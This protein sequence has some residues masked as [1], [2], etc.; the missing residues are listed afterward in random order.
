MTHRILWNNN[1]FQMSL[2]VLFCLC[3]PVFSATAPIPI[4]KIPQITAEKASILTSAKT[5]EPEAWKKAAV[6]RTFKN[7]SQSLGQ[8]PV[9]TEFYLFHDDTQLLVAAHCAE[10]DFSNAKAFPRNTNDDL[11][12]DESVQIVLGLEG[13]INTTVAAGG[14]EGAYNELGKCDHIYEMTTNLVGVSSRRYDETALPNA[15]FTSVLV[16]SENSWT[17]LFHIPFASVG[18]DIKK[19]PMLFFNAFR[20][21]RSERYGW[22]LPSFGGYSKL[23]MAQAQLLTQGHDAEATV[24][25]SL[26]PKVTSQTTQP[27]VLGRLDLDYYAAAGEVGAE[28]PSGREGSSIT[29]TVD[30]EKVSGI[31]SRHW[32]TRL[33]LPVKAA[34][35]TKI[36]AM[37][38]C[39]GK[40]LLKKEFTVKEPL[41][42]RTNVAKEYLDERVVYPWTSP[43][44]ADGAVSLKHGSIYFGEEMLPVSIKSCRNKEILSG[45]ITLEAEANGQPVLVNHR[46]SFSKTA[47]AIEMASNINPGWELKTRTEYDGF[48]TVR[49]RLTGLDTTIPDTLRLH[50]P[51]AKGLGQYMI[52]D[53]SQ[54]LI[55][56]GGFGYAGNMSDSLWVG[57][58]DGGI[59][60]TFGH[61]VIFSNADGRQV[62]MK[63]DELIITM[64][65]KDGLKPPAGN[66]FEFH[67]QF[68]PFRNDI[69]SPLN[70]SLWF[71]VWSRFQSYPDLT[72]IPEMTQRA[73]QA[74]KKGKDFYVY[75]GQVMAENAPEFEQYPTDFTAYP[76]RPWYKRAYD[77]GKG[78]PCSVV[79]FRGEVGEFLLDKIE[80]L[81]EQ[82]GLHGVYLDGPT[83][84]FW[85]LNLNH[86]CSPFLS[87]QWD[88]SWHEGNV[89]GQR[90]YLKRLRGIFHSHGIKNPIW[91]HTGGG[92]NLATFSHCDYYSDG[93]HLSRYRRDYLVPPDIFS[94]I[95]SGLPF[96]FQGTLWPSF[97]MDATMTNPFRHANAWC[98]PHGIVSAFNT[99]SYFEDFMK[100]TKRNPDTVFYPYMREQPHL[101]HLNQ[102]TLCTSYYLAEDE[103]VLISSNL[104]YNGTQENILDISDMFPGKKLQVHCLNRDE[105]PKFADGKLQFMIAEGDMRIYHISPI[106]IDIAKF[107]LMD[108]KRKMAEVPS[109]VPLNTQKGFDTS[110][111]QVESGIFTPVTESD[112][113]CVLTASD[114]N[115]AVLRYKESLPNNVNLKLRF[116]HSGKF[117]FSIDGID[118]S[119][120]YRYTTGGIY[121][122]GGWVIENV[123][124]YDYQ[125]RCDVS[126]ASGGRNYIVLDRPVDVDIYIINNRISF[127]YDGIRVLQYALPA[128]NYEKGHALSLETKDNNWIAFEQ[129][130]FGPCQESQM[131]RWIHPIR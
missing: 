33:K 64:V 4:V 19:S 32:P 58:F 103:A 61:K 6:I 126:T 65:S 67:L 102:N 94:V 74:K 124:R 37:L 95:Y 28:I 100:I 12:L 11:T 56:L 80:T 47:T 13:K 129:L 50:I 81:V 17:V 113:P 123:D 15:R 63:D 40:E 93:E 91:H 27:I 85:C 10:N 39:D 114:K 1:L 68:T 48:M 36:T 77:P 72:K 75:F 66:V 34:P 97:F 71:E 46:K 20:F 3:A 76:R 82:T 108:P 107:G 8:I 62:E 44:F 116:R 115:N 2:S 30:G 24:E 29:L 117:K 53:N 109:A 106:S 111:W 86:P 35:G 88:G 69:I 5:F 18:Y 45:P 112:L 96:G 9:L 38:S 70:A 16:R 51:L 121:H 78:I 57:D 99:Q 118:I 26:A 125:D 7:P 49:A 83:V 101:K 79:C 25:E 55:K 131:P 54:S 87:A 90:S 42:W 119:Y 105:H 122:A 59:L 92:F 130:Y 23:P 41:K 31:G 73:L 84:P 43:E 22:Y 128:V 89:A 14:Y 60:F 127:F 21:Y 104:V 98:A 52:K 120:N 110:K